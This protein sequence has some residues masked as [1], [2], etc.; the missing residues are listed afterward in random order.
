VETLLALSRALA[1]G[2]AVIWEPRDRP[3]LRVGAQWAAPLRRDTGPVREILRRAVTFRAQIEDSLG[4]PVVPY[5]VL[6]GAPECRAGRCLSCGSPASSGWRCSLCLA[7]IYIALGHLTL[8]P[9][10]IAAA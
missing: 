2:G 5:L 1:E 7:A 6:P 9:E 3:R 8:L 4:G 10:I